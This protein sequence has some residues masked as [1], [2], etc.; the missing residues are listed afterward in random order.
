M[1]VVCRVAFLCLSFKREKLDSLEKAFRKHT[2]KSMS[3]KK[4]KNSIQIQLSVTIQIQKISVCVGHAA[5][6]YGPLTQVHT[7]NNSLHN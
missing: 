7:G 5:N 4:R 6:T 1:S 3:S 2:T